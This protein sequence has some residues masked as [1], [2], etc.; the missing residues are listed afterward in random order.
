MVIVCLCTAAL[1]FSEC[2][3]LVE[4][5]VAV[6]TYNSHTWQALSWP[7]KYSSTHLAIVV[8]GQK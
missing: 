4:A 7:I 8:I 5:T 1:W 6:V 3:R 2:A